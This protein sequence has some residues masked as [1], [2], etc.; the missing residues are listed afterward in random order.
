MFESRIPGSARR[1]L[2]AAARGALGGS[3]IALCLL[4][5]ALPASAATVF[6]NEI[7]YDNTGT[8]SGEAIEV[9]GPAGTDLTG[10]SLVLYN[11]SGGAPYGTTALS[12][13]IPDQ[14][15]GY[16]TVFVSYP[17][18]GIQ[19]GSPDGVALVDAGS[20]VVQFLSYEGTMTAVGGPA[21][22][23]LSVDI[24]VSEPGTGPVGESLQLTGTGSVSDDFTWAASMPNTFGAVNTGQTFGAGGGSPANPVI[25]EFVANHVGTDD[26][27]YV[28]VYGDASTDYSAFTVLQIEGDSGLGTIDS[29]TPVGT[30]DAAGLWSTGFL[31]NALQNGSMTLLLVKDFT[32][33]VGDDVDADDDGLLDTI[34]WSSI[35]DS[36]AVSDGGAG[37]GHYSDV[38]LAPGFD[39]DGTTPGGASRIPDGTDT[40]SVADW[41]RN[42]FD[43]AGLPGFTGT[44]VF[45]EAYNTPGA[46]NQAVPAPLPNLVINEIDYDQPSTDTAEFIEIKNTGATA[47]DLDP[48][49]LVLVNG[50]GGGAAVYQTID[51]PSFSLAAGGYYVVCGDASQVINCNLDV[52]PDSNLIQNGSPDAVALVSGTTIIDT[53]SYEGDTGAPYTEGTGAG[54]EDPGT[55]G[56]DYLGISRFPDGADSDQNNVDLSA[57]CITPGSANASAASG[58]SQPVRNPVIINEI[59]YDQPG[60]DTAEFIELKNVSGSPVDLDPY[61][62]QLV[63]GNG[64][65]AVVYKTIDLPAVTLAAGDY[66]VICGNA[67]TV[68]N[69]DLDVSP[70]TDLVQNGAPDA[71]GLL[72][73]GALVDAV[74]YEG[75]TGAPYTEGS[76]TG[77]ED[78]GTTGSDFLGISRF[79]DGADTDVNNVDFSP[80]CITPGGPNTV[81][82][83]NC[84]ATGPQFEIWEIQGS[85]LTSPFVGGVVSTN[86]NI[87]TALAS[88]GFFIQTPDARSDGDVN[89]SDGIFVFT[90]SAPAVA[91]GDQVDVSGTVSEFFDFTEIDGSTVTVDSSGNPL[92]TAVTFDASVPSPDPT[93]P[94]CAIEY[95]CYEGMRIQITGGSVSGP[96]QRFS[97]DPIAEVH[98]VA[99]PQRAFREPGIQYPGLPG[100]PVW[101]GNPEVF[102]LDPDRLGLPN[103]IIPAGSHF[104]A[105]GVLGYEFGGYELWPTALSV[106]PATLPRPVRAREPGEF[107]V[108]SL[109]M[110]RFFDDIDDPPSVNTEGGVRDEDPNEVV[111]SA[112]F[113]RRR[114]K[115][116]RYILGVLDAPDVLAVEE[117]EKL[118]NL[119]T[120]AADIAAADPSVHYTAYLVEGNDIGTIDTGIMV[121]DTVRVDAVTQLGYSETYI[122]PNNGLPELLHD[123]P[124]LLL[125]GAYTGGGADFP[126]EVMAVHNR[127]LSGIDSPTDG[128]RV[129]A[130]RLAQAESIAQ[131]VQ[132]IQT[133]DPSVHLVVI[134]DFNAYEVTDGYVDAVGQI[135][136]DFTPA[137]NQLSGPDLVDPNLTIQTLTLPPEERYSFIFSGTAQ[138]ID[139]ALTSSALTPLVDT[140][141]YG[142]GDADAAVDLINDDTT[143]LRSSDHDGQVLFIRT[144]SDGDGV[145]DQNDLCPGTVIPESVPGDHLL[146]LRYALTDGDDIFDTPAPPHGHLTPPTFTTEDTGGCSC[147]QI[148]D[149]LHLGAFQ[150]RYGCGLG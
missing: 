124:P 88:D 87:V 74:S 146:L 35:V 31:T 129:R 68:A 17:S 4:A 1:T 95:E 144:D 82:A 54:L 78:P 106:T 111:S 8:D 115:F 90:G 138:A 53:V 30:T 128:P 50:N 114:T 127:S 133:A 97:T 29:A 5:T 41:V 98:I 14:Q 142:R 10:W 13:V 27:E 38:V 121:R 119:Q 143:P 75:D 64:G 57:R 77:L 73:S 145:L 147:E 61:D 23:L 141:A 37:D 135:A 108:G 105:E 39:G 52:S 149:R 109:N 56:S 83:T 33:S 84:S 148:I 43:G 40:D 21:D 28:E 62:V 122:N 32:G 70:D 65:G 117:V 134:G 34:F 59:D 137:D 3:A 89:T 130:K 136:G 16:G 15:N 112:E 12:G 58:C 45:G 132:D 150:H 104:D 91:V 2:S 60:S 101:D 96:N 100:L 44:P 22:G 66:Y 126:I 25:N 20:A 116:V 99:G 9:A 103:Q 51:L 113:L 86:D 131:K 140:Y 47:V 42:D 18:N 69:C 71:V 24:G 55:T 85:G 72:L 118:E 76:G 81:F 19:N 123:R 79:P 80:R 11:G 46:G 94:S 63:N 102:E 36:V 6:I 48:Y 110:Y 107:T 93:A 49:S 139:H 92:P 26:H 120:L 67:A 125:E 7:H